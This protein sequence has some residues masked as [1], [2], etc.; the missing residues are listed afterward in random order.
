MGFVPLVPPGIKTMP[1]SLFSQ[2]KMGVF[3][4]TL[5]ETPRA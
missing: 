2:D 1:K 4:K 5:P 3:R